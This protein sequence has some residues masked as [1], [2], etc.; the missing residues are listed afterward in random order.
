MLFNTE[1]V[2][3]SINV[4]IRNNELERICRLFSQRRFGF[5][6]KMRRDVH[7]L[8]LWG[9]SYLYSIVPASR[10]TKPHLRDSFN[11]KTEMI[12]GPGILLTLWT[13]VVYAPYVNYDVII[14]T[15]YP[16]T[17][18]F[19]RFIGRDGT[20]VFA[21][22]AKG[23]TRRGIHF[24]ERTEAWLARRAPNVIDFSLRRYLR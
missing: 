2:M 8:G 15:R 11:M 23:F 20:V 7:T 10:L 9:I 3:I 6:G 21:R 12:S 18:K 24:V 14:P 17:R 16:R 13:D 19:M 1:L 5:L 4:K 22:K